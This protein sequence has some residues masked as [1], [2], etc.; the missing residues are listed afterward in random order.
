[1]RFHVFEARAPGSHP[2]SKPARVQH[3]ADSAE[4]RSGEGSALNANAG[5]APGPARRPPRRWRRPA[6]PDLGGVPA[7]HREAERWFGEGEMRSD[8]SA[9]GSSLTGAT[10]PAI[11]P[12]RYL[13]HPG[14]PPHH[15]ERELEARASGGPRHL[16]LRRAGEAAPSAVVSF[17]PN[18][19]RVPNP[20]A[21]RSR[22]PRDAMHQDGPSDSRHGE[23]IKRKEPS[24][25]W[26]R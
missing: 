15:G 14:T 9:P 2:R 11:A 21:N 18:H 26:I 23:G 8:E 25:P 4:S 10:V 22:K 13:P 16:P 19:R 17:P 6:A 20:R 7:A 5:S 24:P 12:W 1:M 3:R